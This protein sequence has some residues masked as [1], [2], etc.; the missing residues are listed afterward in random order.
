MTSLVNEC[1]DNL[2]ELGNLY[3]V[4]LAWIPAHK[5]FHGTE[6]ADKLAKEAALCV[7]VGPE[8]FLPLSK[9]SVTSSIRE[10][11]ETNHRKLWRDSSCRTTTHI[12]S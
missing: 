7:T 12:S 5:G 1:L 6:E 9:S 2:I 8:P 11:A 10:W 4:K 3:N